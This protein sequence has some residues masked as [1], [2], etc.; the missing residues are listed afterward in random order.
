MS[1]GPTSVRDLLDD[2]LVEAVTSLSTT[3]GADDPPERQYVSHGTVTWDCDLLAVHLV[4][5][6]PKLLDP[7]AERCAIVHMASIAVTL[8]RCIPK[9]DDRGNP[10]SPDELDEANRQLAVDG[11]AL[12][13]GLTRAW[14][15]GSW[16][17][18]VPCK[19][20]KWGGLEPLAP[21]GGL[22]GW[23]VEATV[24]L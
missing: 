9:P 16:P 15:E 20:V 7:R 8:L 18:G 23:R 10:P 1:T 17:S 4:R 19:N 2:L 24:Q 11:W 3:E 22:A 21:S 5:V 6:A 12:W 14:A 13:K